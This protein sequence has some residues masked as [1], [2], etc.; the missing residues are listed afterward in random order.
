MSH[1]PNCDHIS[2]TQLVALLATDTTYLRCVSARTRQYCLRFMQRIFADT[3]T[4]LLNDIYHDALIVLYEKAKAGNFTLTSSL[5]TYLNSV[6]RNQLLHTLKLNARVQELHTTLQD[7]E[8]EY[9]T[10]IHDSLHTPHQG[11]NN[12]RVQAI[13]KSLELMKGKGD[14]HELLL[15]VHYHNKSMKDIAAHFGYKNEQIARNKNYLCRE[16]LKALVFRT[17]KQLKP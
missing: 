10:A 15:L 2:D 6:C 9:D 11:I 4:N 13:V 1:Q 7:L 17:M 14:C 16:Q 5:Q 8:G 12:D 3:D